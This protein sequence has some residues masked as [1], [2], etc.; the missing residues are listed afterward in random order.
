[1]SSEWLPI[2]GAS[3]VWAHFERKKDSSE[4]RCIKC[5]NTF[6]SNSTTTLRYHLKNKH[7]IEAE[8]IKVDSRSSSAT[9]GASTSTSSTGPT[10][11]I[12]SFLQNREPQG[13][14][15]YI[16]YIYTFTPVNTHTN[17]QI[18]VKSSTL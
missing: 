6:K 9:T 15:M 14:C 12:A 11:N 13:Y 2:D 17:R 18:Y 16:I 8:K 1:M 10:Q 4:L 3:P 5:K 7:G